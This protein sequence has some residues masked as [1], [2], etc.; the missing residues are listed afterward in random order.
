MITSEYSTK[1]DRKTLIKLWGTSSANKPVN[2]YGSLIIANASLYYEMD[3]SK[4]FRYDEENKKWW[5]QEDRLYNDDDTFH[6]ISLW[7][8]STDTKPIEK[9]GSLYLENGSVFREIDTSDKYRYDKTTKAWIKQTPMTTG[10][11][12]G[13]DTGLDVGVTDENL[14]F[15]KEV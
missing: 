14:V 6:K 10:G 13:G 1:D 8:L 15:T 9:Y 3:T 4:S 7:G 5:V 11:G 12:G 2:K